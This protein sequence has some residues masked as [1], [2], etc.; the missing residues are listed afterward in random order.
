LVVSQF[1][2]I[3]FGMLDRLCIALRY[4]KKGFKPTG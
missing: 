4:G 3:L 1:E 2:F